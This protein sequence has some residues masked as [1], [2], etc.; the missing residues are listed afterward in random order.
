MLVKIHCYCFLS[1]P[2][3]LKVNAVIMTLV[4]TVSNNIPL[5]CTFRQY[6][7]SCGC[8]RVQKHNSTFKAKGYNTFHTL[9]DL[10]LPLR[11]PMSQMWLPRNLVQQNCTFFSNRSSIS[12]FCFIVE[13][14]N[15]Q[16][17]HFKS[18]V[19]SYSVQKCFLRGW[20]K[21]FNRQTKNKITGE[22]VSPQKSKNVSHVFCCISSIISK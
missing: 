2:A 18:L 15:N 5:Y 8:W 14:L 11:E 3:A 7:S 22:T 6:K 21:M 19:V 13:T 16:Q 20:G 1:T 17:L 4:T 10:P 12:W 9:T